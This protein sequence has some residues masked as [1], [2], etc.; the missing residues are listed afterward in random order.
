MFLMISEGERDYGK[1]ILAK[2]RLTIIKYQYNKT[3]KVQTQ[4][5]IV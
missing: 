4:Q 5:L 2:N 3:S 1:G